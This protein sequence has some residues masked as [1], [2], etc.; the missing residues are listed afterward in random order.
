MTPDKAIERILELSAEAQAK[1]RDAAK[2]SP[3]F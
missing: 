3:A 1:I 2:N